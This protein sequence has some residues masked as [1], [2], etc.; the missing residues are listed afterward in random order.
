[1]TD[2]HWYLLK[3]YLSN[4][5]E[6][7]VV[8]LSKKCWILTISFVVYFAFTSNLRWNISFQIEK[9]GYPHHH[10]C[11]EELRV[12]GKITSPWSL[13]RLETVWS[14]ENGVQ[15]WR[16]VY[17][18]VGWSQGKWSNFIL[19]R[20]KIWGWLFFLILW[21]LYLRTIAGI[22]MQLHLITRKFLIISLNNCK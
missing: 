11:L 9:Q 8:F 22:C 6:D 20:I 5:E 14:W 2:L 7:I 1:M 3:F 17:W 21:A 4:N 10:F 13:Y 19:G 16:S 18:R 12:K 15:E